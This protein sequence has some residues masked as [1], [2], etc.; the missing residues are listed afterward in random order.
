MQDLELKASLSPPP[1]S[2]SL[3]QI[4]CLGTLVHES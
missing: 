4:I 1:L 2:L 3:N